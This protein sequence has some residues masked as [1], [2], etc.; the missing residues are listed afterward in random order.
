MAIISIETPYSPPQQKQADQP[1]ILIR[2][3]TAAE[4][5][6]ARKE[7]AGYS[8]SAQIERQEEERAQQI[9]W[10]K[11]LARRYEREGILT[12]NMF[13]ELKELGKQQPFVL[14]EFIANL[15]NKEPFY[16]AFHEFSRQNGNNKRG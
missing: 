13:E 6:F 1:G 11:S 16:N 3:L 2:F 5:Y 7:E 12:K 8:K 10:G 14:A 15:K 4:K 9:E